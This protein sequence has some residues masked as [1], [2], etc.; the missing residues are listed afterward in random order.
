[1]KK[2]RP[3]LPKTPTGISGLDEI[4][5]GGLPTGRPTLICGAAGCGKTLL[6]LEFIVRGA[7]Q[8]NEPG[9][10]MA[11]EEAGK[12]IAQNSASLGFEIDRLVARKKL[13]VDSVLVERTDFVETG[14]YD[15]EG[16]FVRLGH[17]I[18]AIG[19]KR[20]ALDTLDSLF[21]SFQDPV[22][23]RS[24]LLRLFRWLK[25][26][27]MTTVIT[28]ERGDGALTRHGMEE[29][30]SDCVIVLDHR[31][32]KEMSA[33]RLRIAKYRGTTHGT[34][35]YPFLIDEDGFS[36]LPVTSFGL[37][38][39]VTTQRIA[40]GI[41]GLDAML[42]GKG[43]YR[44]S[45]I[46]VSGTAGTG[47]SSI[48][49]HFVDATCRRGERAL[50]FAFEESPDQIV[51]NMRSIGIDLG[52]SMKKGLLRIQAA[53][54][55]LYGLEMH[56]STMIKAVQTFKP[57]VVVVDPLNSF[58]SGGNSN[59]IKMMLMRLVDFLKTV[60]ITGLFT[61]LTMGDN[62]IESTNVAISSLIDTWVLLR[63]IEASGERN[64]AL[65]LL[66]SRGMAHSNQVREFLLTDGGAQ[67]RDVYIGPAGILTGSARAAQEAL[68]EAAQRLREEEIG[69]RQRG[70][71]PKRELLDAQTGHSRLVHVKAN[72]GKRMPR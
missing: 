11:F 1:M 33:R 66:K 10:F 15:L 49:A 40:T 69:R 51:R 22:I 50:Y 68:D 53:R 59:D 23:L 72:G 14:Q 20:V 70:F 35:E 24:E 62:A 45:S 55:T 41:P 13:V 34:N 27:G 67:L 44:G 18:D 46:L 37:A 26:K 57:S 2:S 48:A 58:I 8:Y 36:V 5:G 54:P 39:T 12:D 17:A 6:A 63:D 30:V 7:T 56:L 47:K 25:A 31:V 65:Y 9:V 38:Q 28:G 61:S 16:L 43:Y 21:S 71:D 52:A 4:T 60:R 3:R 64:R 32:D 42:G 19:A 29:Y